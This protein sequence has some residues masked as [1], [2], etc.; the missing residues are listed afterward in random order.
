MIRDQSWFWSIPGLFVAIACTVVV[1][2]NPVPEPVAY[3]I[4]KI[5]L[6]NLGV[7][8]PC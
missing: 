2:I 5:M 4:G 3:G 6:L 7:F 1:V 8:A